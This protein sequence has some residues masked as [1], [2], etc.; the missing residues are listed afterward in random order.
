MHNFEDELL[1]SC[2]EE[3][4]STSSCPDERN[5]SRAFTL[6]RLVR[7]RGD[8]GVETG[9]PCSVENARVTMSYDSVYHGVKV[10]S[11]LHRLRLSSQ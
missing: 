11:I 7:E 5:K 9:T 1:D 6:S 4:L 8:S 2:Q 3:V 10:P